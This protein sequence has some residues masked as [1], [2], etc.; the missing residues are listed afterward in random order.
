MR[1]SRFVPSFLKPVV[2]PVYAAFRKLFRRSLLRHGTLQELHEYWRRP[3]DGA[4]SPKDYLRQTER[5]EFLLQILKKHSC[6]SESRI[7]EI[8]CNAG[9]NLHHLWKAGYKQLGGIEISKDAIELLRSQFTD[10][11]EH[12]R[13][14]SSPV[15]QVIRGMHNNDFDVVFTMAVLEHIHRDSEW[16]F[17]EIAR[18]TGHILITIEDEKG[19]SFRHFSR[20]YQKVFEPLGLS[21]LESIQCSHDTAGLGSSFVARV[22]KK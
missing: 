4:N 3:S 22:F 13:I 12:I 21:Q 20:N 19:E 10:M 18:I 1:L 5:S 2:R 6:S 8:G 14:W 17:A 9:R 11:V 7:L 16:V 15:E